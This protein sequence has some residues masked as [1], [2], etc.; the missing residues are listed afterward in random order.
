MMRLTD[1][2]M[3]Y[4]ASF[5]GIIVLIVGTPPTVFGDEQ[6]GSAD[7]E[8]GSPVSTDNTCVSTD[9][10]AYGEMVLGDQRPSTA[11]SDGSRLP[12]RGKRIVAYYISWAV[13]VRD[14]HPL[15]IPAEKVTH[16][17]YAF[18]NIGAD[19]RITLGDPYADVEKWYPGDTWNQP[20]RGAYNQLNNR[21]R[22]LYP[23]VQTL[24]SVGGWTWSGRFSDVALT[25]ESRA[26]FAQS[27]VE[28]I[29]EYNFD[30]VDIDW[31][32]PVCCGLPGNTYRP[33]DKENYTLLMAELRGQ[34]DAAG[35]QSGRYYWLTIAGPAGYDKMENFELG[36]IA[37]HLD[38][39]NVMC[40]DF[41]GAW[42]LSLTNHHTPLYPNPADPTP[43][44]D[45]RTKYNT[46]WALNG[47]LA[48][49]VPPY[50]TVMGV[51][52]YG[53]AWGG[54]P[55]AN[56]GLFQPATHVPPGTWDDWVSGPTGVNDFW[57][58]QQF[59]NSGTYT[60]HWDEHALV[61]WLYSPNQHGG[62]F[63]SYDDEASMQLKVEYVLDH[64]LGGMMFWEVT[65]D[66]NQTLVNII[67]DGLG[68]VL[69]GDL[70]CDSVL[71][72]FDIDPF[73]LA[74]TDPAG[75]AAAWPDCDIMLADCNGDGEVNAFDIDPF[76]ELL[77]G[78]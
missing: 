30:G 64:H 29:Q 8:R 47:W 61:P 37:E 41:H 40:Y 14:Y 38:W 9:R 27:C 75:Y 33:E 17:N 35:A 10:Q 39:V 44:P 71:N 5:G 67:H 15:D 56:G 52:F 55:N 57:Q 1:T 3:R 60:R 6:A 65:A 36:P 11:A 68:A 72:A 54:V 76:V 46:D 58:I 73:V 31:E 42:E 22:A 45:I 69:I 20:Y 77:T 63:I 48:G 26:S 51:P 28:H 23:H 53:R 7:Y 4:A 25:P 13:Y 21:L 66:R 32:Y 19:L 16:I 59:A 18:A 50:K 49:G 78:G 12:R 34:L 62:H 70:N 24:I 43:D 74:L 2:L